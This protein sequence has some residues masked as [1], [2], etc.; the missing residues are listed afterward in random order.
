MQPCLINSAGVSIASFEVKVAEMSGR[1][2]QVDGLSTHSRLTTLLNKVADALDHR[3]G[4]GLVLG[5]RVLTDDQGGQTMC[6]LCITAGIVMTVVKLE[7]SLIYKFSGLV[8]DEDEHPLAT[9]HTIVRVCLS[10]DTCVLVR[11]TILR[12]WH[13]PSDSFRSSCT[14]DICRGS[15]NK[16]EAG[17]ALCSWPQQFRRVRSGTTTAGKFSVNDSGWIRRETIPTSWRNIEIHNDDKWT[18]KRG[19]II[20]GECVLGVRLNGKGGA[21]EV[22]ETLALA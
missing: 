6:E 5:D 12:M 10:G 17:A 2:H 19:K 8:G 4:L 16:T 22:L 11:R 14:Y 21:A 15:Y 20:D 9:N 1:M 18:S 7:G 3:G 13:A